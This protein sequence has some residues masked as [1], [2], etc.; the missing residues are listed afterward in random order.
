MGIDMHIKLTNGTPET[1]T[2]GQLRKDNPQVSF[3]K[4]LTDAILASYDVFP[5]TQVNRPAYDRIT[6]NLTEGTP[7]IV[8]GVWT[9][10]WEISEASPEEIE[11][12]TA[13]LSASV[14]SERDRLLADTDWIVIKAYERNENIP[15]EWGVY[16]QALRDITAQ[17]GFP[18]AVVWPKKP[19]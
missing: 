9:Q 10:V 18:T 14:R 13:D 19:E 15:S 16:R 6:Q 2:I 4:N 7:A 11:Q 8:D 12:R 17:E 1:Y 5:V 3:P